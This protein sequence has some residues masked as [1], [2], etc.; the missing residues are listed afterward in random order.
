MSDYKR[1]FAQWRKKHGKDIC[2]NLAEVVDTDLGF[3]VGQ[4]VTYTNDNGVKFGP[5]EIMGFCKPTSWGACVYLDFDCYWCPVSLK[6][7]KPYK[8]KAHR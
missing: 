8:P 1:D 2:D 6:S 3:K 4:Q 7:I 5:H